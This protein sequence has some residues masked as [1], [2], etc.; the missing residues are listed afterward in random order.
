[1]T[2]LHFIHSSVS[3]KIST[4][5]NAANGWKCICV[6]VR[7]YLLVRLLRK[8]FDVFARNTHGLS[9]CTSTHT[10]RCEPACSNVK[11]VRFLFQPNWFSMMPKNTHT[12]PTTAPQKAQHGKTEQ[13]ETQSQYEIF[14]DLR[15]CKLDF[16][17][18][19]D[20]TTLIPC[21]FDKPVSIIWSCICFN[22]QSP[23]CYVCIISH[24]IFV[25]KVREILERKQMISQKVNEINIL[26]TYSLPTHMEYSHQQV[27]NGKF[28]RIRTTHSDRN[29]NDD[30]SAFGQLQMCANICPCISYLS[31]TSFLFSSPYRALCFTVTHRAYESDVL[32]FYFDRFVLFVYL[33]GLPNMHKIR[34]A[35]AK[36]SIFNYDAIPRYYTHISMQSV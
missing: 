28:K 2:V 18:C 33:F 13:K 25:L 29:E 32:H 22:V 36:N 16:G 15:A 19:I 8:Y 35:K 31:I 14:C 23:K 5:R 27:V 1:M 21:I 26:Y 20:W 12:H 34:P 11:S 6:L 9:V 10:N 7:V 3:L 17:V 24:S 4:L 30:C